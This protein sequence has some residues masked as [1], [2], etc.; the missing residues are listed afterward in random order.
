MT[1]NILKMGKNVSLIRNRC[2]SKQRRIKHRRAERAPPPPFEFFGGLF[3]YNT[4]M[5]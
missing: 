3:M 2:F 5:L 1:D 4:H